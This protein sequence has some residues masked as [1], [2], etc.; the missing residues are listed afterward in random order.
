MF[1]LPVMRRFWSSSHS[2]NL[3]SVANG[4]I[5]L[6]TS[7]ALSPSLPFLQNRLPVPASYEMS[8][9]YGSHLPMS[10]SPAVSIEVLAD[11]APDQRYGRILLFAS[12]RLS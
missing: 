1:S 9:R 5:P 10:A 6:M 11:L 8:G 7:S 12:Q 4:S 3:R 2:L